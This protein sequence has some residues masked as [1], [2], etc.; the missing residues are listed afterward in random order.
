MKQLRDLFLML[1]KEYGMT[2][3]ISSHLLSEIE[4]IAHTIGI[5][6]KGSLVREISMKEISDNGLE[7][8]EIKTTET[9]KA[10]YIF[11]DRLHISNFKVL[12]DN[13]IRIYAKQATSQEIMK[14]LTDSQIQIQGFHTQ[15]ESLEEYFLKV[16]GGESECGN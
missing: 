7:Y 14:A 5:I 11:T 9:A 10:S 15:S 4:S 2:I 6:H 1:C 3:L 12:N 8:L 13:R 16:T